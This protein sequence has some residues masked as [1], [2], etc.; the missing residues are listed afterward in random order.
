MRISIDDLMQHSYVLTADECQ[1]AR[2]NAE[3]ARC[4]L[5]PLPTPFIGRKV[6]RR[7]KEYLFNRHYLAAHYSHMQIC[8][9]ANKNNW[10]YVCIFEDDAY[11]CRNVLRELG[12]LLSDIPD[13]ALICR[14]GYVPYKGVCMKSGGGWR[15]ILDGIFSDMYTGGSHAYIVFSGFFAE[16]RRMIAKFNADILPL[17]AV[18]SMH[19][20]RCYGQKELLNV[21]F[22]EWLMAP[23]V[24][25]H[26]FQDRIYSVGM[27][28]NLFVQYAFI[29]WN[30]ISRIRF[31]PSLRLEVKRKF[32]SLRR[33]VKEKLS[34]ILGWFA[35]N[36]LSEEIP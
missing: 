28:D 23:V 21:W 9:I 22:Y 24:Y 30:N 14:L 5:L 6:D 16:N 4:G 2:F 1:L 17:A 31:K 27:A 25:H 12:F 35:R 11:P 13:D 36:P 32:A 10:P 3:F 15:P 26:E 29:E 34:R 18:R 20:P 33:L 7:S 19:H 8:D